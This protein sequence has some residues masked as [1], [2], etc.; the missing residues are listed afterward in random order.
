M[1]N[2][3]IAYNHQLSYV[4]AIIYFNDELSGATALSFL[5]APWLAQLPL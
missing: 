5:S 2:D 4:R 1:S 3:I